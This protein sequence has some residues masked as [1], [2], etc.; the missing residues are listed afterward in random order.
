MQK[1]KSSKRAPNATVQRAPL[2][3]S[4]PNVP[5]AES[6]KAPAGGKDARSAHDKDGNTAQAPAKSKTSRR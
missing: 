1:T 4:K 3:E 5:G 6:S 2:K